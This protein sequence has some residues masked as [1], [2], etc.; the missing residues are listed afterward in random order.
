MRGF[1]VVRRE[2]GMVVAAVGED[3]RGKWGEF[4]LTRASKKRRGKRMKRR[5]RTVPGIQILNRI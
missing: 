1:F 5:R 4:G 3:G 2:V